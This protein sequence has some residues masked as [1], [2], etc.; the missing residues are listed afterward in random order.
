MKVRSF[1]PAVLALTAM[2]A[3]VAPAHAE[4]RTETV[5]YRQAVL[6]RFSAC[7]DLHVLNQGGACFMVRDGE[8]TVRLEVADD[9][10]PAVAF[11]VVAPRRPDR[12][13]GH[14]APHRA[15]FADLGVHCS[16]HDVTLELPDGT[17]SVSIMM[18]DADPAG[19][20]GEAA[21]DHTTGTVVATFG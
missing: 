8:R 3:T 5:T 17:A 9:T 12:P 18:E 1:A 21:G 6:F 4:G 7:D 14:G 11:R 2:V 15:S 20:C 13:G 10:A 16:T 19:P